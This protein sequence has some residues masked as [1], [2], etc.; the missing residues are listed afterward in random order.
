[1]GKDNYL[2]VNGWYTF[3]MSSLAVVVVLFLT[4]I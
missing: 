4:A 3:K 2:L 1:M